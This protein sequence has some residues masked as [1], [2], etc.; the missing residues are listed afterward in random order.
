MVVN[1][2]E[3][4]VMSCVFEFV[5][6][7]LCGVNLQVGVV[8]FF[9]VGDVLVEGWYCG[10]G[11]LYVEVDV[12]LKLVLDV[13]YGVIVV[14]MFEFCNYIGCIGF[15]VVVLIEVGVVCVVYVFD[16][17]GVVLGGGV[18]WLCVVGVEVEFGEQVDVVGV[19]IEG[20]FMVQCFGCLYVIVKWVQSLDGCVVVVDG[21]SQW[22]IGFIV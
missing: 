13:V 20:W 12:L 22:I 21:L 4:I 1:V 16:D 17:L 5:V 15:C 18:E 7:G 3:C 10:V 6:W 19:L 11:I 9:F 2:V 14:V 8:I